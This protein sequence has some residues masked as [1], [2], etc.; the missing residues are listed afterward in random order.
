MRFQ[1]D[2]KREEL[3]KKIDDIALAMIDET[4]K[5]EAIYLK[6]LKEKLFENFSSSFD[7]SQ[8]I[9]NE[10]NQ[11]EETFRDPNL[12]IK[13]IKQMQRKQEESLNEIQFK[14]N[15]MNQVR[16]DLKETNEFKLNLSSFN[17]KSIKLDGFG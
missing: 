1:I 4:K 7:E 17:Q 3:K 12:L 9:E 13:T 6:N 14:L 2:Q 16:D 10:L 5:Y 15:E 11:I 8:S